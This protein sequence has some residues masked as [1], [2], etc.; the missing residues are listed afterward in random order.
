MDSFASK[1]WFLCIT[2]SIICMLLCY[3]YINT[4]SLWIL[5][6]TCVQNETWKQDIIAL[7]TVAYLELLQATW[8]MTAIS[9]MYHI[10]FSVLS[11]LFWPLA[12]LHVVHMLFSSAKN[13]SAW[14]F[15]ATWRTGYKSLPQWR[16]SMKG[17]GRERVMLVIAGQTNG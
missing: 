1:Y 3:W 17:G 7:G 4:K 6:L 8:Q 10:R 2:Y 12:M 14:S 15:V 9:T 13:F 5:A 11:W 16:G